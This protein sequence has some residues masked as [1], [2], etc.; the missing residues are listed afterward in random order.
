MSVHRYP[1][2]CFQKFNSIRAQDEACIGYFVIRDIGLF[3]RDTGIF[4]F[5]F[6]FRIWDIQ[7]FWD[8]GYWNLFWDMN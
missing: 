1:Q 3:L 2:S 6:I 4:V 8:M 7:E 5:F